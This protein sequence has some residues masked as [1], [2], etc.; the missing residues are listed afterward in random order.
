MNGQAKALVPAL[1]GIITLLLTGIT[2]CGSTSGEQQAINI[3]ETRAVT[4]EQH[5]YQELDTA[6]RMEADKAA[7]EIRLEI[8]TDL[9]VDINSDSFVQLAAAQAAHRERG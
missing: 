1:I 4:I 8:A 7:R 2:G 3:A 9:A 6:F 5:R